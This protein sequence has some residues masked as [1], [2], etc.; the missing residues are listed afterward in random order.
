MESID[1]DEGS[2]RNSVRIPDRRAS[3]SLAECTGLVLSRDEVS[4]THA[5][6][7]GRLIRRVGACRLTCV[8]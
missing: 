6:K 2:V 8:C 4:V 3:A 5:A 7:W 1:R